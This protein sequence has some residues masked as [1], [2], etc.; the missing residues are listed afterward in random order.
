M[1]VRYFERV[2]HWFNDL[3][4][5][6]YDVLVEKEGKTKYIIGVVFEEVLFPLG[7]SVGGVQKRIKVDTELNLN[8]EMKKD[9]P[10]NRLMGE[11]VSIKK[12]AKAQNRL[13]KLI[14]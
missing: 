3:V 5:G 2:P 6:V 7:T 9:D 4:E 13:S 12:T 1:Y 11:H 14:P 8:I 10:L